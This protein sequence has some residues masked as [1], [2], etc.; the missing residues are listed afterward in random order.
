M[1]KAEREERVWVQSDLTQKLRQDPKEG[2]A[3]FGVVVWQDPY[4]LHLPLCLAPL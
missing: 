3:E 1:R 4:L 2:K